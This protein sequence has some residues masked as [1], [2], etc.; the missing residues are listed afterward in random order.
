MAKEDKN[1][2]LAWPKR[3]AQSIAFGAVDAV[4]ETMPTMFT[5][6]ENNKEA[7][8]QIYQELLG[9]R[10]QLAKL[11]TIQDTYIFKP[12]K[13]L[14][15]NIK[16]DL[17]SGVFYHPERAAKA[18]ED[19]TKALMENLLKEAGME[20]LMG[21]LTGEEEMTDTEV[22][23]LPITPV[24][25]ITSGDAFVAT[26]VAQEQRYATN[27]L[28]KVQSDIA[29]AQMHATRTMGNMQLRATQRYTNITQRGFEAMIQGFNNISDFHNSV[30][31]KH[32]ENSTQYYETMTQLTQENNAILKEMVEMKRNQ[33]KAAQ[34]EED[35]N[36]A[37]NKSDL[38]KNGVFD[39]STYMKIVESNASSAL[40]MFNM[41][42][43]MI[44]GFIA[45]I[46]SNPMQYITKQMISTMI[47]PGVRLAMKKFD[48]SITG[49][50][51]TGLAKLGDFGNDP[52][53]GILSFIGKLFGITTA[54]V[55]INKTL[56]KDIK[57]PRSWDGEDHFYLTK[58]IPSFLSNIEA[59]L[60]GNDARIFNSAT[61]KF[62]TVSGLKKKFDQNEQRMANNN[63]GELK[64]NMRNVLFSMLRID[65]DDI[66]SVRKYNDALNKFALGMQE[67]GKIDKVDDILNDK[68]FGENDNMRRL[69]HAALTVATNND[70]GILAR[71]NGNIIQSKHAEAERRLK[72]RNLDDIEMNMAMGTHLQFQG[73]RGFSIGDQIPFLTHNP[74]ISS[75]TDESATNSLIGWSE[76]IYTVLTEIRDYSKSG[77][78]LF[79]GGK[80]AGQRAEADRQKQAKKQ[81]KEQEKAA[82]KEKDER[83]KRLSHGGPRSI[84]DID[85]SNSDPLDPINLAKKYK[86]VKEFYLSDDFRD[87]IDQWYDEN[88]PTEALKQAEIH[89]T[90]RDDLDKINA[91]EG[92]W[93]QMASI[94]LLQ[95]QGK[96]VG[97]RSE[98]SYSATDIE[99]NAAAAKALSRHIIDNSEKSGAIIKSNELFAEQS[100][101]DQILGINTS[102]QSINNKI[103]QAGGDHNKSI[104]E[105]LARASTIGQKIAIMSAGIDKIALA[106]RTILTSVL[107]TADKMMYE[108]MFGKNTGDKRRDGSPIH[109]LFDKCRLKWKMLLIILILVFLKQQMLYFILENLYGIR[110]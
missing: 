39:L 87:N 97:I 106:P 9:S 102:Q 70:P 100:F 91:G 77:W 79:G 53:N 20:D 27:S 7:A 42:P 83:A 4:R 45:G 11:K 8:K 34:E 21:M 69:L 52:K 13:E 78:S 62:T 92:Q 80:T 82:Q 57:Q 61:G 88:G 26:T 33:Y 51:S 25:E 30:I 5:T 16:A 64:E 95:D 72:G 49:Y 12:A 84:D 93:D 3:V 58:V 2:I 85:A 6:V 89:I 73:G 19:S 90:Y 74:L 96:G 98:R 37:P 47:G 35:P 15:K 54:K 75:K 14:M 105:N 67:K 76:K 103:D 65:Q 24:A 18:E 1:S 66:E 50:I 59:A 48:R 94:K 109:G 28:A 46:V 10:Q 81:Q 31:F 44:Q 108:F 29:E 40:M 32:V 36:K 22:Q 110:D 56:I 71:A 55:D 17:K 107:T 63:V 86:T 43:A 23:D 41:I 104:L 101:L 99:R 68:T 60:T 38:F